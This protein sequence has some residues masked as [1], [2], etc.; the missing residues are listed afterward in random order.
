MT[1]TPDYAENLKKLHERKT[2]GNRSK[3]PSEVLRC[4]EEYDVKSILDFGCGKGLVVAALKETFPNLTVYGYDPGRDGYDSLPDNVDM[5]ISTDVL[6]HIEPELLNE[7]LLDLARRTNKVMYHLIACHPAKK[8]LPDGRNAHL[9]VET[10]QWWK[11]RLSSVLN[12]KMYNEKIDQYLAQVKK[13]PD[14]PVTKYT[15]TLEKNGNT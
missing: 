6:E 9:I 12:W 5:I 14:I 11:N 10:P 7:T 13:G 2:F 3:I 4:I 1:I 15:V 8:S